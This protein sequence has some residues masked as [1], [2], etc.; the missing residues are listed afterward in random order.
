MQEENR[1]LSS[2]NT[3]FIASLA[4]ICC[5]YG[6]VLPFS[7]ASPALRGIGLPPGLITCRGTSPPST[8]EEEVA[9]AVLRLY[10][11]YQDEDEGILVS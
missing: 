4:H 10:F 5:N 11:G 3:K 1:Q 7:T 6:D 9:E 8:R 2:F